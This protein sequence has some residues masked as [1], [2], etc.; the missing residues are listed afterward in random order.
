MVVQLGVQRWFDLAF[1]S[2]VFEALLAL[3]ERPVDAELPLQDALIFGHRSAELLFGAEFTASA[4][5]IERGDVLS[6]D[7]F[8]ESR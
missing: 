8:P 2:T 4:A 3:L 6:S 7:P 1:Q 5:G